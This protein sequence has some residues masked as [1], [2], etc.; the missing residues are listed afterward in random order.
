MSNWE[1]FQTW[2]DNQELNIYPIFISKRLNL[3]HK[4]RIKKYDKARISKSK[5]YQ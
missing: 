5:K 3:I 4:C 1:E 2:I